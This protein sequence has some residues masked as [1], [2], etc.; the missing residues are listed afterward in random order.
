MKKYIEINNKLYAIY[1]VDSLTIREFEN[2]QNELKDEKDDTKIALIILKYL[3]NLKD[4]QLKSIVPV[5]L[6]FI[7]WTEIMKMSDVDT[8]NIKDEYELK[9]H[10]LKLYNFDNIRLGNWIDIDY[11]MQE[12]DTMPLVLSL[13]FFKGQYTEETIKLLEDDILDNLRIRDA[14]T[15]FKV[16]TDWRTKIFEDFSFLFKVVEPDEEEEKKNVSNW[17][18]IAYSLTNEDLTKLDNIHDRPIIE[19]LNWMTFLKEK[20]EEEK[21]AQKGLNRIH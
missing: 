8:K 12:D 3:T 14:F 19:I 17:S 21:E 1:D 20:R 2:L 10:T 5:S 9:D 13:L 15:I 4:W 7:D 11:F 18:T 16:F 6:N